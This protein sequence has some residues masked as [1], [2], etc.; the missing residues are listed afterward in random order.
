VKKKASLLG[1]HFIQDRTIGCRAY[2]LTFA[3]L[4]VNLALASSI[5][6]VVAFIVTV[7]GFLL[8]RKVGESFEKIAEAIGGIVLIGIG[9]RIVLTH[10]LQLILPATPPIRCTFLIFR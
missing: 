5:M 6:G 2:R 4:E 8:G 9:L 1:T 3:F 10:I 7:I